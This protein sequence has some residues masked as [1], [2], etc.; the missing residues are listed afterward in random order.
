MQFGEAYKISPS[1]SRKEKKVEV[2]LFGQKKEG[3]GLRNGWDPS[4]ILKGGGI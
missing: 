1:S 2:A 3:L 4:T